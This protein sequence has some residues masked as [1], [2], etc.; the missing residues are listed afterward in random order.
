MRTTKSA[1][2]AT[3]LENGRRSRRWL[4]LFTVALGLLVSTKWYGV[5]GFG[6][7]FLVLFLL[8]L[9]AAICAPLRPALWGNPRGFRLDGALATIVFVAATIYGSVWIPD[10]A[11]HSP[12][13]GEI[14][15]LNDVVYRQYSM[16]EYHHNLRSDAPVFIA[17]VGVA[18]RLRSGG[19]FLSGPAQ[20][21]QRITTDVA[22]TRS[23]RCPIRSF[24]GSGSCAFLSSRSWRGENAIRRT[25][26]SL[27]PI[28][29]NGFR[30]FSPP[31]H[32]RVPFLRRHP[33]DLPLQCDRA[34]TPLALVR[35]RGPIC[36]GWEARL[37][38]VTLRLRRRRSS[39]FSHSPAHPI[40]WNAWHA[41]MWFPTWIIGPG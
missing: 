25:R 22:S 34:A 19:I 32:L 8:W 2:P 5:M 14:H 40:T 1:T 31:G 27:L 37:W 23:R 36:A 17:V 11:R 33:P 6:V 38:A 20:E 16:Y 29:C 15:N 41:R 3:T 28:S 30:G 9:T 7:S 18:D 26:C 10:L 39:S 24:C 4:M 12:D 13:P 21:R 35:R